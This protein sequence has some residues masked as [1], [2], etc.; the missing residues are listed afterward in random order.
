M[1]KISENLLIEQVNLINR[2]N[3]L[4]IEDSLES[5][6]PI[7]ITR[8]NF[9]EPPRNESFGLNSYLF[10][11][12]KFV[13][14]CHMMGKGLLSMFD[15]D[16]LQDSY[17]SSYTSLI[18]NDATANG[19]KLYKVGYDVIFNNQCIGLLLLCPRQS[20][21][22]QVECSLKIHN[23]ILYQGNWTLI[24]DAVMDDMGI[25]INNITSLD[26][27]CDSDYSFIQD[28]QKL[29]KGEYVNVGRSTHSN[30]QT[31]K[32]V[33]TGFYIGKRS[34][35]KHINGY[36]KSKELEKSLKTYIKDYWVKNGLK[37]DN[38]ERL[39]LRLKSKGVK[40]LGDAFDISRLEDQ[41]YLAGIMQC[42]MV[43][44]YQFVRASDLSKDSNISRTKKIDPIDF[45]NLELSK[46]NK[47]KK[48][49]K[50]SLVW[51][52]QRY[53]T[54]GLQRIYA[55]C[56]A[57]QNLFDNKKMKELQEIAEEYQIISWF[58]S[59]KKR[60]A[61]RDK[62]IIAELKYNNMEMKAT[63]KSIYVTNH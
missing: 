39:E 58:N 32:N 17:E 61:E 14:H 54:F 13:A 43:G 7:G 11:V 10:T 25:L 48:I 41:A 23:H 30:I 53:I 52:A 31:S 28:Y 37:S 29:N 9:T 50:P 26:I 47:V 36:L 60:I 3:N 24:L 59:L 21:R 6:T 44:Y 57:N 27:A 49:K 12:D 33:M 16:D 55:G 34:S 62:A 19:T 20:F 38:V 56:E 2:G 46:I 18:K 63:G 35:D 1:T 40:S 22:D 8:V 4:K 51:S 42:Q 5:Q 45:Y 15:P